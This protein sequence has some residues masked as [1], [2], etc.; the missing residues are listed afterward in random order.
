MHNQHPDDPSQQMVFLP[1]V[2]RVAAGD[3][4]RFEPTS[5]GHNVVSTSG[6]LP[7]GAKSFSGP[8]SKPFEVHFEKPGHYGYHCL[9]HRSMG[10]V[11]LVIVDGE[12]RDANLEASKAVKH[13]GS[14]AKVWDEIWA[15]LKK[16]KGAASSSKSKS[17]QKK[18]S[19]H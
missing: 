8:F 6:M 16:G 12:G 4:V 18:A 17:N 1:R 10:M 5:P 2:L 3:T 11:G 13:S 7:K 14:A 9:A 19:K 15:S